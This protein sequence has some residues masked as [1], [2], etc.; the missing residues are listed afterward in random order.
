MIRGGGEGW[1]FCV[2]LFKILFSIRDLIA[3]N[4]VF[5]DRFICF[6]DFWF[7]CFVRSK[8]KYVCYWL[9]IGWE[10]KGGDGIKMIIEKEFSVV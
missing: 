8:Y 4:F 1:G 5:E 6:R 7:I 10:V 2:Y 3:L 9:V